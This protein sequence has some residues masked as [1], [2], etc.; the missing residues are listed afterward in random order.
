MNTLDINI[1]SKEVVLEVKI[2]DGA[3]VCVDIPLIFVVNANVTSGGDS[4]YVSFVEEQNKTEEEQA[5]ARENIGL[6]DEIFGNITKVNE[7]F[8]VMGVNVGNLKDG[9]LIQGKE[10]D[11]I[12]TAWDVLKRMLTK[13]IDVIANL[14]TITLNS[15]K[16]I[17]KVELGSSLEQSLYVTYNDGKFVGQSGYTYNQNAGCVQ[18]NTT[19]KRNGNDIQYVNTT[20]FTQ[21]GNVT[22]TAETSYGES[23]LVPIK[24]DGTESNVRIVSGVATSS[25]TINV[26]KKIFYGNVSEVLTSNSQIR[27]LTNI[28]NGATTI[29][30]PNIGNGI[31]IVMPQGRSITYA[32]TGNN[33]PF[34]NEAIDEFD[35]RDVT[36]EYDNGTTETYISASVIPAT[37]MATDVTITIG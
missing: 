22:F 13:V 37:P 34:K 9:D 2:G 30:I 31:M 1:D 14:P 19:F 7:D 4:N 21:V 11:T 18:G 28:W 5:R 27:Q 33:Q 32:I 26:S 25:F 8:R 29:S 35:Y 24:N 20:T 15:D 3:Y 36:I 23:T 6:S 12:I 10:G 17:R 16:S